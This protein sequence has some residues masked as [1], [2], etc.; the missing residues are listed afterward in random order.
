MTIEYVIKGGRVIDASGETFADVLVR[1]GEIVGIGP[2]LNG[3]RTIDAT[4]CVVAPGLVD[5]HT[6]L[7]EPGKEEA[8]TIESEQRSRPRWLHRGARHAEHHPRNRLCV[9][10]A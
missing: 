7:R 5:L 10:R 1:D 6:H 4:G 8:E 3:S 2:D 9:G